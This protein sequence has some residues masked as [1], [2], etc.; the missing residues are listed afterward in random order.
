MQTAV[1]IMQILQSYSVNCK[2][3]GTGWEDVETFLP[4]ILT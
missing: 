3:S 2:D 1:R 4:M